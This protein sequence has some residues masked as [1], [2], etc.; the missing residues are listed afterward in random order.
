MKKVITLIAVIHVL[1]CGIFE[2]NVA[3]SEDL[4]YEHVYPKLGVIVEF[5]YAEDLVFVAD[6]NGDIWSFEGTEDWTLW[7]YVNMIF[8]DNGTPDDIYDD[9]ILMTYYERVDLI[10][11]Q[12]LESIRNAHPQ[13]Y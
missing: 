8:H 9:V 12:V 6:W 4:N 3:L 13:W 2:V 7:D 10:Q 5:D 1:L 11:A